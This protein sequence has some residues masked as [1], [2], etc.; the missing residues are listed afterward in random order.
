[1]NSNAENTQK[2]FVCHLIR[3]KNSSTK[4]T[5]IYLRAFNLYRALDGGVQ[6]WTSLACSHRFNVFDDG[7]QVQRRPLQRLDTWGPM[8]DSR[9]RGVQSYVDP[10]A[11]PNDDR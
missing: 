1:M 6:F 4:E 7:G 9:G 8:D 5:L 3:S 2:K 11:N 10:L